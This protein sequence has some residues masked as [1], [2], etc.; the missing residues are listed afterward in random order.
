ML[1]DNLGN[2]FDYKVCIFD[3]TSYCNYMY[4]DINF[5]FVAPN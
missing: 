3:A 2:L 4:K 5:Y 1:Q